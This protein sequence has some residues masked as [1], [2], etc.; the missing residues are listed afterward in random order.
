MDFWTI[1][2]SVYFIINIIGTLCLY[3]IPVLVLFYRAE[4]TLYLQMDIMPPWIGKANP[5]FFMID[6]HQDRVREGISAFFP[7]HCGVPN[8]R[9]RIL[10]YHI[11]TLRKI[12]Y[13]HKLVCGIL[14]IV[15]FLHYLRLY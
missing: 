9:P 12:L 15:G 7:R 3:T 11:K 10:E 2:I 14:S 13:P 6:A 1:T 5:L 4:I 8:D